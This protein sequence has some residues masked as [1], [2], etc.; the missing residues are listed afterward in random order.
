M[1]ENLDVS[2]L[3]VDRDAA[4][5]V[6]GTE[7]PV[8]VA[9]QNEAITRVVAAKHR[10][11][12]KIV[13]GKQ[14]VDAAIVVEILRERCARRRELHFGWQWSKCER[15]ISIVDR[16]RRREVVRL[17]HFRA[18]PVRFGEYALQGAGTEAGIRLVFLA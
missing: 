13:A 4:L 6:D 1:A 18:A 10:R 14:K 15:S 16:H 17:E 8:A 3:A 12:P 9:S 2:H 5:E 7:L 11:H